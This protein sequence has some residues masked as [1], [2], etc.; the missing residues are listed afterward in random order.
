M[1]TQ[2]TLFF[3]N[4]LLQAL[5]PADHRGDVVRAEASVATPE[6]RTD[7]GV[8]GGDAREHR[9]VARPPMEL[10]VGPGHAA[11]VLA[12]QGQHRG[13]DIQVDDLVAHVSHCRQPMASSRSV[14]ASASNR[15]KSS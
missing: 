7:D 3:R 10:G 2:T 14:S 5:G 13:V 4:V 12:I 9:M 11:L 8:C 1:R 6:L 15:A